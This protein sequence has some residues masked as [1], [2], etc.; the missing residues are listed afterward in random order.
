[1]FKTIM[2]KLDLQIKIG[3]LKPCISVP[4]F[5]ATEVWLNYF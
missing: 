3:N 2:K 5:E 4:T 1:M